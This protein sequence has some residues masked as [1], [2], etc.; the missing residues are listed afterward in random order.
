MKTVLS[1]IVVFSYHS[2]AERQ[3]KSDYATVENFRI[4]LN[5]L[6]NRSR[7]QRQHRSGAEISS[8][9]DATDKEFKE[10]KE[11]LDNSLYPDNYLTTISDLHGR[12][13]VRQRD[14]GIIETQVTHIAELE[15]KIKELSEQ[16]GKLNEQNDK[17]LADVQR[18]SEN[19]KKLTGDAFS[20]LT[21]IDSLR[22]QIV[23]LRAGLAERDALIFSLV[24]SLFLQYDKN[25]TDMKDVE[26]Q[27]LLGKVE[28][29]GI[30]A[31]IKRSLQD[32]SV[33]L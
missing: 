3:Q 1:M 2:A 18:L 29:H 6:Q 8:V 17:I 9:L 12:L 7:L 5:L 16:I 15:A 28:H 31:N 13:L 19:V 32:K 27:G 11:L 14:L 25:V 24:D 26:R 10:Y 20:S 4:Q 33:R 22:R 21:P 30:F 23:Q